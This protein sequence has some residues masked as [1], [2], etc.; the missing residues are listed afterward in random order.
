M[1]F[2]QHLAVASRWASFAPIA[3]DVFSLRDF[4][5]LIA[6]VDDGDNRQMAV[7]R[8]Q[9]WWN[10]FPRRA[11]HSA[12]HQTCRPECQLLRDGLR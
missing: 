4:T 9:I 8:P 3:G 2:K 7:T 6:T 1:L 5:S 11:E 10:D 12:S